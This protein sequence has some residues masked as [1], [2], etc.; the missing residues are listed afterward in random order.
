MQFN[1]PTSTRKQ[2]MTTPHLK[3]S[4]DPSPSPLAL[5]LIPLLLACFAIPAMGERDE[6]PNHKEFFINSIRQVPSPCGSEE[7]DIRGLLKLKFGFGEFANQRM[8]MPV[9]RNL[10]KGIGQ[11]VCPNSGGCE[12]G[13]GLS[14]GRKYMADKTIT[15]NNVANKIDSQNKIKGVYGTGTCTIK[16]FVTGN[17]NPPGQG[18][19]CPGC[20]FKRFSIEYTL[21]YEF[22]KNHKVT[23][24]GLKV[25]KQKTSDIR[26]PN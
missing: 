18:D 5:L 21:S 6:T 1:N 13:K 8:F 20:T 10:A 22:N 7:V 4:M 11:K 14:T 9:D 24:D 12:V 17:P 16:L 15:I 3:K 23:P 26:C 19:P 25:I 2:N